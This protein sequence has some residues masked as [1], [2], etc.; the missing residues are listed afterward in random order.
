V[1]SAY[2]PRSTYGYKGAHY[3]QKISRFGCEDA[4]SGLTFKDMNEQAN[5]A[6][7]ELPEHLVTKYGEDHVYG[8]HKYVTMKVNEFTV[9]RVKSK[10][11]SSPK[12]QLDVEASTQVSSKDSV[13]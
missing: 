13:V 10:V 3:K 12:S 11:A 6:A 1:R 7:T 2:Y 8:D 5:A 4:L 9:T